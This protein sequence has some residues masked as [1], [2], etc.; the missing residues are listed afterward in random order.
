[1]NHKRPA[2]VEASQGS[3]SR[4]MGEASGMTVELADG[5]AQWTGV[6]QHLQSEESRTQVVAVVQLLVLLG[7]LRPFASF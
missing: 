2:L 5:S 7:V 3:S 6:A 1:M 4:W